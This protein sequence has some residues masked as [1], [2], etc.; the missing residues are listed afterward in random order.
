MN[1]SHAYL[2][3][4]ASFALAGV[5]V[6]ALASV[7]SPASATIPA[8]ATAAVA[9][10]PH[11]S[12]P[13]PFDAVALIA[14][15]AFVYDATTGE[16]LFEKNADAQLPLA[17]LT[18]LMTALT[19]RTAAPRYAL[20][21]LAGEGEWSL[22]DLLSFTLMSSSNDGAM[23]AAAVGGSFFSKTGAEAESRQQF[24]VAMN[25]EAEALGLP[26]VYFLNETGLDENTEI[27]GGYGSARDAG[28]LIAFAY[29]AHPELFDATTQMHTFFT[30]ENGA[31]YSADNT[32]KIVADIP[33]LRAS[34]T[35][36]TDLA[37]GNLAVL[38]E[39]GVGKPIVVAVLGSTEE[40]R[41]SD[42]QTLVAVTLAHLQRNDS[43][44]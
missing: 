44:I 34:K 1:K 10:A 27:A 30:E 19:A 38:F 39:V 40:G 31:R 43:P 35:G 8:A 12:A 20:I 9:A 24:I 4:F 2:R 17:S 23:A 11:S 29:R 25:H 22:N 5:L 32:N 26:S 33:M 21:P 41:F 42:V 18:K 6:G 36:L 13:S 15:A 14:R 3:F 37:G 28:R 16:T 7:S